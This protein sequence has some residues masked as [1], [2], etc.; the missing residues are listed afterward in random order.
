MRPFL[1][2]TDKVQDAVG[3][4][5]PIYD[6]VYSLDGAHLIAGAGAEV[7][8]Y[9]ATDGELLKALKAHKDTVTSLCPLKGNGFASGG[10][11]KQVIIW[12]AKWEGVLKY[13][14]GDSIQSLS[15]NP[16]TGL[17]LSCTCSDFGLWAPDV[18]LSTRPRLVPS[19]IL[20]SS[21]TPDGQHFA[22]GLYNG[23]VS[24]RS[25][26]G[27][28][29]VRIERGSSP[30]WSVAWSPAT[31]LESDVLAVTDWSQKLSF[32]QLSG[33]QVGK[34][35]ILGF[36]PC[37]VSYFSTGE[38]LILGGSDR[39]VHLWTQDGIKIA[40]IC[41]RD[42]WIW[43][44]KVRPKQNFIAVGS[45]DGTISMYQ[46]IFNTVHGLYNDRYAFRQ[47]MTD[48][49]IQHLT[50][51]Q[52][53]RIKCRDYVKKISIYKDRLAVQLPD[54]IIIYE[55]FHDDAGDMHYRIKEK[56]Q[57]NLDCNLLVVTS[58]HIILCLERKLQMFSFLG[59]MEREWSLDTLIRYIKVIGGP[60]G[61]EG[62]LVG[63]KDGQVFKIFIDSPFPIPLI[64]HQ[65]AI[66]CL[67]LNVS[68]TKLAVV[69]E[70]NTCLVYSVKSKDLLFQEPNANSVAWNTEMDDMLCFSGNGVLNVKVGSFPVHQ[71]KVSGF[72]STSMDRYMEKADFAAAYQVACLGVPEADWRRL[73]LDAMEHLQLDIAKEAFIRIRDFRF[74]EVIRTI[75]K[76]K[77]EGRKDNDLFLAQVSAFAGKYHEAA[78]L[79]KRAGHIQRAIEI[80]TELNL[81]EFATQLAEESDG[82]TE[83]I[84]KRKAQMQE[85]RKDLLAAAATYEQVGE[86]MQAIEIL[87]PAG[88]LDRLIE[89]VRKVNAKT[90]AKEL[91]KC[92]MYFRKHGNHAFAAETYQKLGDVTSLLQLHIELQQ[93]DEAFKIGEIN[94]EFNEQIYLPYGHWLAMHDRFEEAQQYYIKA[95]RPDE[96]IRVLKRLAENAIIQQ[97]FDD[98]AFYFWILSKEHLETIPADLTEAQLST[99]H[100]RALAD[101]YTSAELAQVYHA[102]HHIFRFI[103][104]PFTFTLP[105]SL[106]NMSKFVYAYTA[107]HRAPQG[108]SKVYTLYTMAKMAR[109]LG[110]FKLSRFALE[111]LL[112]M[113]VPPRWHDAIDLATI[114]VRSKPVSDAED[115]CVVCYQ[116]SSVNPPLH[117]RDAVCSNCG[118]RFV[119]SMYSFHSLPV[120]QFGLEPGISDAEA[121]KLIALDPLEASGGGGMGGVGG[122]TGSI[123]GRGSHGNMRD[124][125]DTEVIARQLADLERT[126]STK[127]VSGPGG[128]GG[129][130]GGSTVDDD[131]PDE[132]GVPS[133]AI[134][135][136]DP[137]S[138]SAAYKPV[139]Y[140]R[141]KLASM[142][143]H[144]VFVRKWSRRCVPTLYYRRVASDAKVAMCPSCSSF[145]LEEEW[146]SEVLSHG[147]CP[148][149]RA[150]MSIDG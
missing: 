129:G 74:L 63:L 11:D 71:Q 92:A 140:G 137:T 146:V 79:F 10:A 111:R 83:D 59:E 95:G 93:W 33:R 128:G 65:T 81:W 18:K 46:I 55:L 31:D 80:F 144:D 98:A 73:A 135:T 114:T 108:I 89:I 34:D 6:L 94:P 143:K 49:V 131:I 61:R 107:T 56:L 147:R 12:N 78:R 86:Y 72:V 27:E 127:R 109:N 145:F 125:D 102:Y 14:H 26:T 13:S 47:N 64:Q 118:D 116:C 58:Q 117:A 119:L 141:K 104:D 77:V 106:L 36:D 35:R 66:R 4:P 84:L 122:S 113:R 76:V 121:Q 132:S 53:A 17:V 21:W 96:A 124:M 75:E 16:V 28:E 9:D 100:R 45:N 91:A 103:E 5:Q 22:L 32:F 99:P 1:V 43:S 133:D 3:T 139:E 50:T 30:V 149:C 40:P 134:R 51:D 70:Q 88:W 123:S 48:V 57:K 130:G 69:D 23:N 24:I 115:L 112:T 120:V 39:K 41:E 25:R 8:V 97:R 7:L 15:Q 142:D 82:K 110:G 42:G 87:G 68:R 126:T 52:R 148:F 29:K 60:R 44:C 54:R 2:W 101:F 90:S 20:C 136:S 62:L 37:A 150:K 105:D 138:A 19:R 67:D 85:D 38:Y